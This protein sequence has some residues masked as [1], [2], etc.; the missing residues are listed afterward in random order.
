MRVLQEVLE[1]PAKLEKSEVRS[2]GEVSAK[3]RSHGFV[4][5]KSMDGPE[6]FGFFL[7]IK[8]LEK[9]GFNGR[10]SFFYKK[11]WFLDL[12]LYKR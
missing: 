2:S 8:S 7:N 5:I 3:R 1:A 6:I 9:G 4:Y 11:G 12:F 10:V